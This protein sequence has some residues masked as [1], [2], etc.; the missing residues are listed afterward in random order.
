MR[1]IGEALGF[2]VVGKHI[3]IA[4]IALLLM[5]G[6]PA[7]IVREVA[8]GVIDTVERVAF[9]SAM[10]KLGNVVIERLKVVAPLIANGYTAASVARIVLGVGIG[11]SLNNVSPCAV[12]R[13]VG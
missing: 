12:K 10:R 13:G 6:C 4:A 5:L 7:Y 8:E 3:G 9:F 11:T 1:P 2:A